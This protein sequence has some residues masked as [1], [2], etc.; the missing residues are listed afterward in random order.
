MKAE[1]AANADS[2]R[3]ERE[4]IDKINTA[5]SL[6]FQTEK[7]IS[8]Y[9][10]KIPEDKKEAILAAVAE[11]KTA[12]ESGDLDIIDAATEKMNQA[13][14][15]ASQD[16]YQAQQQAQANNGADAHSE[17]DNGQSSDS[18]AG[19]DVEDVEFEEVVDDETK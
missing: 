8:E 19:E 5:D 12:K 7:N 13:W 16:I 15:A 17:S 4:K 3:Q 2:D 10:D 6:I 14:Q 1:A 18:A 11:L 9:G